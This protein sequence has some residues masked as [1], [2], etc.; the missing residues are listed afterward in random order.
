MKQ[1]IIEKILKEENLDKAIVFA[2][3]KLKVKEMA[4]ILSKCGLDVGAMHS[5]LTQAER[6]EIMYNFK[7]GKINILVATDIISRGIDIDDIQMVINYDVPRDSEE[8][9]EPTEPDKPSPL[10]VHRISNLSTKLKN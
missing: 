8:Q 6:D 5:D 4:R 3:S 1:R 10:Y 7:N 2:S 9:P